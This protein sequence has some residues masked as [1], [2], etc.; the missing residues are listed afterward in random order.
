MKKPVTIV[1][2]TCDRLNK[3]KLALGSLLEKTKYPYRL[4][5]VDNNSID[6]TREYL[7]ENY[8]WF[9]RLV[10]L[11]EN[12]GPARASNIGWSLGPKDYYVKFDNDMVVLKEDWLDVLVDYADG[13]EK[14]E[15][16]GHSPHNQI[17]DKIHINGR[18]IMVNPAMAHILGACNLVTKK[19]F[20]GI[21]F[22]N[23]KDFGV[24]GWEEFDYGVRLRM[25]KMDYCYVGGVGYVKHLGEEM[26]KSDPEYYIKGKERDR[27]YGEKLRY[28]ILEEYKSGK[29]SLKVELPL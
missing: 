18:V 15:W 7:L 19:A 5:V 6:G 20:E 21:G 12:K 16:I 23:S 17:F 25:A 3:T 10:L 2:V 29:R 8:K 28:K 13:L 4:I 26:D 22:W 9:H 1:M 11:N 27:A 24:Y 14:Y